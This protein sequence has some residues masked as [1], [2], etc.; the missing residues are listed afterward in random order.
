[1]V[2]EKKIIRRFEKMVEK[3]PRFA[4]LKKE[5]LLEEI[6]K[7]LREE[8]ANEGIRQRI[9]RAIGPQ[10]E[11]KTK[12]IY[13]SGKMTGLEAHEIAQNFKDAKKQLC[14]PD[15][16]PISPTGIDYGDKLAWA[17]YMRLDEVLIQICDAIYMLSNWQD[18]PGACH[19][20]EYA[21]SLGKPVI[22]QEDPEDVE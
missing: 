20:L 17:E 22:Y 13:I 12:R 18:S 1:M 2:D 21:R 15:V 10:D 8:A 11:M 9:R 14:R 7:M 16:I 3:T 4:G 5:A 19:E 6:I